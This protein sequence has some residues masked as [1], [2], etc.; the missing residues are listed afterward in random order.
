[1]SAMQVKMDTVANNIANVDKTAFKE[2]VTIF[3]ANP[4]VLIHRTRDDGVGWMP[5]GGFDISPLVG[6]L[7][8]A[9]VVALTAPAI[10]ALTTAQMGALTTAQISA[11]TTT[12]IAALETVDIKAL[13]TAQVAAFTTSQIGA[14]SSAQV[15]A[16]FL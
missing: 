6:K 15:N 11:L 1:M 5:M 14:M 8:T 10:T 2:D 13:S 12:Q 3:R 7:G 16:L 9:Q 4:E